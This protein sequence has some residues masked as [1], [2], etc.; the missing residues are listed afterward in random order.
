MSAL[1]GVPCDNQ[2]LCVICVYSDFFLISCSVNLL[3]IDLSK[4]K[5]N[6]IIIVVV[7]AVVV[8]III[9]IWG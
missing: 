8:V 3:Y 1:S 2:A 5:S 9:V 7:I 6:I 4:I